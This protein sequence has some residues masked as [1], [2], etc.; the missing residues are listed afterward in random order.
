MGI[1]EVVAAGVVGAG[2]VGAGV[3]AAGVVVAGLVVA[4]VVVVGVV[5]PPQAT[6]KVRPTI[7]NAVRDRTTFLFIPLKPP[8]NSALYHR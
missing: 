8:L 4:G 5:P 7:R 6:S 2:V 3:V 1:A